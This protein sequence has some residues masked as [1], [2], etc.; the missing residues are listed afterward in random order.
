MDNVVNAK[1]VSGTI[2]VN[3]KILYVDGTSDIES[4]S[5]RAKAIRYEDYEYDANA[6]NNNNGTPFTYYDNIEFN[7]LKVDFYGQIVFGVMDYHN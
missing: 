7:E 6:N 4:I 5:V 1:G 2:K 3:Y